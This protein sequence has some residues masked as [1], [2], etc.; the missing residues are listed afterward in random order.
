[1]YVVN[2]FQKMV[3]EWPMRRRWSLFVKIEGDPLNTQHAQHRP[4]TR[5]DESLAPCYP[6]LQQRCSVHPRYPRRRRRRLRRR[7][8]LVKMRRRRWWWSFLVKIEWDPLNTQHAQ[9]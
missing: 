6:Y 7:S 1:M 9:H 5:T 8:L 2:A 4:K 3:F